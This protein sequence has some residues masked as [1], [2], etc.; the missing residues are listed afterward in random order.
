ME[1]VQLHCSR[2]RYSC[3]IRRAIRCAG[4][5]GG[6]RPRPWVG[7]CGCYARAV[8]RRAGAPIDL[9]S[10]NDAPIVLAH[11]VVEGGRCLFARDDDIETEFVTRTRTRF[12]DFAP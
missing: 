7:T 3:P 11:E 9:V 5:M 4:A 1:G 8:E 2:R 6:C 12:W 10:L